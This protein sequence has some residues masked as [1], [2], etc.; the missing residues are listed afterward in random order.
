[1]FLPQFGSSLSYQW[2]DGRAAK[3]EQTSLPL[4]QWSEASTACS[5]GEG[6]HHGHLP[7]EFTDNIDTKIKACLCE[8][9]V[10]ATAAPII[11]T[12]EVSVTIADP[13]LCD[14]PFIAMSKG[15][16]MLTGYQRH[17]MVGLNSRFLNQG[18][19]LHA[20]EVMSDWRTAHMTGSAF[21]GVL[22]TRRK[23]GETF[24]HVQ[25][26]RGLI[27]AEGTNDEIWFLVGIHADVSNLVAEDLADAQ[28]LAFNRLAS[29]I[30][31]R[32]LGALASMAIMG[33]ITTRP[34]ER[35]WPEIMLPD[36]KNT[37]GSSW[38]LL[39]Q[40]KW[41][42]SMKAT[43]SMPQFQTLTDGSL[44]T[45]PGI[46]MTSSRGSSPSSSRASSPAPL[47]HSSKQRMAMPSF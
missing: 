31:K 5:F 7:T 46:F 25:D 22:E 32:L 23:S 33:A 18:V 45:L 44:G 1:M 19:E 43:P 26:L 35:G 39:P 9:E 17:E 16:E 14:M 37:A 47:G 29:D 34:Q 10:T 2:C 40:P 36:Q 41:K 24:L 20:A 3:S 11:G 28:L 30:R 15:F 8:S 38:R 6:A 27:I 12:V 13:R 21:T 42:P 4:R